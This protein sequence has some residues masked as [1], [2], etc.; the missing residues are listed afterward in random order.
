MP[1]R[2]GSEEELVQMRQA[3]AS[4]TQA[5]TVLEAALATSDDSKNDPE[6]R[7]AQIQLAGAEAARQQIAQPLE[8]AQREFA[9]YL[10]FGGI[11]LAA[12]IGLVFLGGAT[13]SMGMFLFGIVTAVVAGFLLMAI[14]KS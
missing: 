10:K 11:G 12:G 4:V 6:V 8:D 3:D 14:G 9:K 1:T 13:E 5:E 7:K 2:R